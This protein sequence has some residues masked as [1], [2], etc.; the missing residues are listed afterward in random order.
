MYNVFFNYECFNLKNISISFIAQRIRM[1]RKWVQNFI[2]V[3]LI[4]AQIMF[5]MGHINLGL[6]L[7]VIFI[8]IVLNKV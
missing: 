6:N 1:Q 2:I 4:L 3:A 8:K 7:N 5:K